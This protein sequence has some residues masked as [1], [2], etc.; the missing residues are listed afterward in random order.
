LSGSWTQR[1]L[2]IGNLKGRRD[3]ADTR[4]DRPTAMLVTI[5]T[6]TGNHWALDAYAQDGYTLVELLVSSLMAVLLLGG[7]LTA[8][9]VSQEVEA[10]DT[11]WTLTLQEG[12]AGLA[13]MAYEIRDASKV[14]KAE[15]GTI[16]FLAPIGG[17]SWQIKYECGITQ[18]GTTYDEC[19]RYAAEEGKSLPTTGAPIVRDV[20]NGTS[21]FSYTYKKPST[22]EEV[23]AAMMKV[24]LSAKGTLKQPGSSAYSK[25]IVLENAAFMRTLDPA[26]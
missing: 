20:L 2:G 23:I 1:L 6:I 16:D 13:R 25:P 14:E 7:I 15:F 3:S 18:T 12:R 9:Q 21:V 17:K 19:V 5:R 8:F 24:E 10:R 22:K 4:I 26:G 11:T